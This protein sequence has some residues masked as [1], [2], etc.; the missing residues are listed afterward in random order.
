MAKTVLY[1]LP[2]VQIDWRFDD[3]FYFIFDVDNGDY[4]F[5][6]RPEDR[7]WDTRADSKNYELADLY[8]RESFMLM[9]YL[10]DQARYILEKFGQMVRN[11]FQFGHI[12]MTEIDLEVG[13]K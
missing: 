3:A 10:E 11:E 1:P 13:R 6:Y 2:N 7:H 9:D 8:R 12:D 5:D 4:R